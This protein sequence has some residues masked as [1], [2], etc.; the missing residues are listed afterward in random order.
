MKSLTQGFFL[1]LVYLEKCFTLNNNLYV[2]INYKYL[3]NMTL[4]WKTIGEKQR[5]T[6]CFM[7]SFLN[8]DLIKFGLCYAIKKSMDWSDIFVIIMLIFVTGL[9]IATGHHCGGEAFQSIFTWFS[10]KYS[11][12]LS[13]TVMAFQPC[14]NITICNLDIA[15][16]CYICFVE[17]VVILF[18]GNLYAYYK[19]INWNFQFMLCSK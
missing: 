16:V 9:E 1:N 4:Q 14:C 10:C 2:N 17:W 6:E 15:T 7:T 11:E 18:A 19:S 5:S 13:S 8:I 12:S 3:Q